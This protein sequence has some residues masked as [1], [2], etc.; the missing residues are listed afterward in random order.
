M[1]INYQILNIN[2]YNKKFVYSVKCKR[3]KKLLCNYILS[4]YQN[5]DIIF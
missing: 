3:R 4:S 5:E 1:I 2:D